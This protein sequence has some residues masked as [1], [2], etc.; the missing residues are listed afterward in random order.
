MLIPLLGLF[1]F[2]ALGQTADCTLSIPASETTIDG[3]SNAAG[4]HPGD[5]ICL[6]PGQKSFLWITHL[7]GSQEAPVVIINK[8]GI[9]SVSQFYYGIK[10]DSCSYVKLSGSGVNGIPYGISI[11][12]V[13]GAGMS[14]EGLSTDIEVEGIEIGNTQLAGIFCKTDPDCSFNSTRDKYTMRNISIHDNYVHDTGMEGFYIGNSFYTGYTVHCGD[15]DTLLLPHLIRGLKVYR[16][17]IL[18]SGWD[19]IQ[20]SS[21]DS[22]CAI[23]HNEIENDS[24]LAELNQMSG[25]IM[26]NGSNCD[27]SNNTIKDGK[28]SGIQVLG[29]GDTK[30]YNNLIVNPGRTYLQE[31]PYMNG[32][33]VGNQSTTP[34]SRFVFAYNSI[35]SPKDYGIDFRNTSAS[36]AIFVN[37]IVMNFG[38]GLSMG[39]N[40]SLQNNRA[41]AAMD[42]LEFVDAGNG[43]FDLRP[44]ASSVNAAIPVSQ[45]ELSDDILDRSRPFST[46]NDIGAYECHDSSLL[47]IPVLDGKPSPEL[48]LIGSGQ[49]GTLTIGYLIPYDGQV[50]VELYD[51]TGQRIRLIECSFMTPGTYQKRV[52]TTNLKQGVYILK[53]SL[54]G[55]MVCRKIFIFN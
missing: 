19:G 6:L 41:S 28:G 43:N 44:T 54:R 16:N 5:T 31:F 55:E 23:H 39:T 30:V 9:V 17:R 15:I 36:G 12:N 26:G 32:I 48:Y 2:T 49:P 51:L 52:S 21:A 29:L 53:L 27:C 13:P 11:N 42:P 38:R 20:V 46:A 37:N 10:I 8:I 35:I 22:S 14:I 1:A 24:E 47:A 7:H 34:G 45:W 33:F 18:R 4:V 40:I 3:R 50:N 25:I